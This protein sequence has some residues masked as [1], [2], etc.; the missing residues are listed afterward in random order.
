MGGQIMKLLDGQNQTNSKL[1]LLTKMME[2][3]KNF[4]GPGNDNCIIL[5]VY[6]ILIHGAH[7]TA[8][9]HVISY[10][11]WVSAKEML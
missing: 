11:R 3:M 6:Q 8:A 4:T 1:S 9:L 2:A 7:E 5:G 10:F